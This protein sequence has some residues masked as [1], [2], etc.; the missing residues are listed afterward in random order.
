MA[1]RRHIIYSGRVQ[2]VGFR[3]TAQRLAQGLPVAGWVR[4]LPNGSVE[5]V[6]E[7]QA[8]MVS[9]YLHRLGN[10]FAGYISSA[11]EQPATAATGLQ[12]FTITT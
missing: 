7:G 6:V 12:G 3:A 10:R 4:N 9:E 11:V 5:L 8:E 2:G 1:E